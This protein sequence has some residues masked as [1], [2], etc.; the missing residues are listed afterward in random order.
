MRF[1]PWL[2]VFVWVFTHSPLLAAPPKGAGPNP[3]KAEVKPTTITADRLEVD[4]KLQMAVYSGHVVLYDQENDLTIRSDRLEFLFDNKME[5]VQKAVATGGVQINSGDRYS[6]AERAEYFPGEQK[7][8]L[9][10]S[11]KVWQNNDTVTGSR[12]ILLLKEDRAIAEG[13]GKTRV[14]AVIYPKSDQGGASPLPGWQRGSR[15]E[16]RCPKGQKFV[17]KEGRCVAE[18]KAPGKD[19]G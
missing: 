13:D 3:S 6:T 9:T 12:V 7:A 11:P 16:G 18:Q 14:Q 1:W 19:G 2:T 5:E 15:G 8:I 17:V 4:R 10:G